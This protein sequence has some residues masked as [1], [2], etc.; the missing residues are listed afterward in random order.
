MSLA[1]RPTIQPLDRHREAEGHPCWVVTDFVVTRLILERAGDGD[2]RH[3]RQRFLISCVA[4]MVTSW[5]SRNGFEYLDALVKRLEVVDL[6][7]RIARVGHPEPRLRID[8]KS[9]DLI[10][11]FAWRVHV[12]AGPR[13]NRKYD[14]DPLA[15]RDDFDRRLAPSRSG[16]RSRP[17][18]VPARGLCRGSRG[19]PRRYSALDTRLRRSEPSRRRSDRR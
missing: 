1:R 18:T 14:G 5:T 3:R 15:W 16:E 17:I 2:A 12:Q 13:P 7:R 11:V 19:S 8:P 10:V 9:H 4:R 6:R